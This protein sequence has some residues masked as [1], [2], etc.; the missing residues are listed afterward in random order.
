ME[1]CM[2]Y[3]SIWYYLNVFSTY[4]K[5]YHIFAFFGVVKSLKKWYFT[6]ITSSRLPK[7]EWC[8][9]SMIY[10]FDLYINLNSWRLDREEDWDLPQP[11]SIFFF[12][13]AAKTNW[14]LRPFPFS[15]FF[16]ATA[17]F[18]F[19]GT[20]QPSTPAH[21]FILHF[22]RIWVRSLTG[23]VTYSI[24]FWRLDWF[25]SGWWVCL[26]SI[27]KIVWPNELNDIWSKTICRTKMIVQSGATFIVFR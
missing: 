8:H 26:M 17:A 4:I 25:D 20:R 15:S 18:R 24:M 21:Q 6:K 16:P 13:L 19:K 22:L 3:L 9:E 23:L 2:S 1:L 10:Q 11:H 14:T 27:I 5:G 12:P 7:A